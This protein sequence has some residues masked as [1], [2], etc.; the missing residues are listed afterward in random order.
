MQL[1]N[2]DV[3]QQQAADLLW[4]Q[5]AQFKTQGQTLVVTTTFPWGG[6]AIPSSK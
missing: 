1:A 2:F 5:G 6:M 4:E 3:R